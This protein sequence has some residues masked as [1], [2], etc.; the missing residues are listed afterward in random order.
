MSRFHPYGRKDREELLSN[1]CIAYLVT[2][3]PIYGSVHELRNQAGYSRTDV[4][5]FFN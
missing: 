5:T 4:P 1:R 3:L 2:G